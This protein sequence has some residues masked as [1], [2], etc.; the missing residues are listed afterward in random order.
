MDFSED[1]AC[2]P[3]SSCRILAGPEQ[4]R[5][6]RRT[7]DLFHTLAGVGR[8]DKDCHTEVARDP[9]WWVDLYMA[10]LL[11]GLEV[12]KDD[13]WSDAGFTISMREEGRDRPRLCRVVVAM[14]LFRAMARGKSK[15]SVYP[16]NYA[17]DEFSR[18]F[19]RRD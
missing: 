19:G 17:W 16:H 6:I 1:N 12:K 11:M 18:V 7:A 4:V 14:D 2:V 5:V 15:A 13:S 8:A 10:A 9:E 3:E